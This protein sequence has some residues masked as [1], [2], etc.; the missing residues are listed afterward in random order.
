M[1]GI[2][3]CQVG[4]SSN[5]YE[6]NRLIEESLTP[7]ENNLIILG[8]DKLYLLTDESRSIPGAYITKIIKS[9][10]SGYRILVN[11][12]NADYTDSADYLINIKRPSIKTLYKKIYD[13]DIH[14]MKKVE[15]EIK[16]AYDLSLTERKSLFDVFRNNFSKKSKDSFNI[17]ERNLIEDRNFDFSRSELPEENAMNQIVYPALIILSTAAAIILFFTIRSN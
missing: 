8:K 17:E 7:L 15:R 6:I 1:R 14:G 2:S 16:V 3:F 5:L 4:S 12:G 13:E 11:S 9:K 10:F